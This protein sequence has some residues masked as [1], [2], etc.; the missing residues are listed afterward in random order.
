MS[1][2]G[3]YAV[4]ALALFAASACTLTR[5]VTAIAPVDREMNVKASL[6]YDTNMNG[7]VTKEEMEA[8]LAKEFAA[9]DRNGDGVLDLPEMQAENQ[10]RFDA[11]QSGFSPLIDWNRDGKL[12]RT[13]FSTTMRSLFAE[14]DDD[15]NGVLAGQELRI[16]RGRPQPP[17]AVAR[18]R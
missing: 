8:G 17:A 13:E 6:V 2:I 11:N 4:F 1:A 3:K 18:R 15:Q 9:A 16:P 7:E 5:P 14:M 12:D 10:R